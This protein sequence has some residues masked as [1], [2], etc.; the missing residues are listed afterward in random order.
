MKKTTEIQYVAV[1]SLAKADLDELKNLLKPID[2]VADEKLRAEIE[3]YGISG[4]HS[5]RSSQE[6]RGQA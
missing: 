1:S 5:R 6:A 2:E 4:R 3:E